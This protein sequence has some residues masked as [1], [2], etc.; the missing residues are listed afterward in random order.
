M[1]LKC[2]F[3]PRHKQM[4]VYLIFLYSEVLSIVSEGGLGSEESPT[5][6]FPVLGG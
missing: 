6:S 4:S 3:Q 2:N 5:L 1:A